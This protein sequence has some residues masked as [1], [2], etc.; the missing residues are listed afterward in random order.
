MESIE[1]YVLPVVRR[2]VASG[3]TCTRWILAS[4]AALAL[5]EPALLWL[6]IPLPGILC[7]MV[8]SF[9]LWLAVSLLLLLAAWCHQVLLAER[10]L[11]LTRWLLLVGSML[12]PAAPVCWLYTTLSGRLLLYRQAELPLF[13]CGLLLLAALMNIPR[14][15][16]ARWQLQLRI[17]LL[18]LLLLAALSLDTPGLV[19]CSTTLKLLAAWQAA[20]LLQWLAAAAPRIISMP[21][22]PAKSSAH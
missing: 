4:C 7:G 2:I 1:Y 20:P 11:A 8:S 6:R 21:E 5:L 22:P 9:L 17:V 19:L 12:A 16:A 10:G 3:A 18:P 15:A 13:F 14:M